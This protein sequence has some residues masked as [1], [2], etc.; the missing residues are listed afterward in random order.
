[1][2]K[3]DYPTFTLRTQIKSKRIFVILMLSWWCFTPLSTIFKLYRG[4]QF[5]WWRKPPNCHKSLTNFITMLYRVH[6]TMNGIQTHNV[7][8]DRH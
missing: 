1:M 2:N 5:Y 3:G 7:S 6:L 4:S 8:G